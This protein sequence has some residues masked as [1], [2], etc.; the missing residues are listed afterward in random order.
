VTT[1]LQLI[2]IIVVFIIIKN[3]TAHSFVTNT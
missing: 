2:N 1:Q 3:T